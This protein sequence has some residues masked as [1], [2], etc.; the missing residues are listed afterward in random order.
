MHVNVW[1][2]SNNNN[3]NNEYTSH[4]PDWQPILLFA[5]C[6]LSQQLFY[7]VHHSRRPS[8]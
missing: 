7:A 5:T 1:E 3:V 4:K 2:N 8:K 6:L